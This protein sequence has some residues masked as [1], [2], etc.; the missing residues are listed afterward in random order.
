[1]LRAWRTPE[2]EKKRLGCR[3][4]DN[5]EEQPPGPVRWV[6]GGQAEVPAGQAGIIVAYE[7]G[8]VVVFRDGPGCGDSGHCSLLRRCGYA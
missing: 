8:G 2:A 1:M 6:L 4:P 3:H 5:G 7:G